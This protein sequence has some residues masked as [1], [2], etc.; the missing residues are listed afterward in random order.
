MKRRPDARV[1]SPRASRAGTTVT[2]VWS[3]GPRQVP[4]V[5]GMQQDEAERTLERAGF[6][7][8]VVEDTST[9]AE[10]GTVLKQSPEAYTTQ[11]QGTT[12]VI[13][14]SNYTEPEPS[15]T[16][17]EPSPTPSESSSPSPSPLP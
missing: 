15:P 1:C 2:V 12:V 9:P 7:V 13:T 4:S 17:T 3:A 16:P 10:P 14:V 6:N 5:V 8:Q 11:S